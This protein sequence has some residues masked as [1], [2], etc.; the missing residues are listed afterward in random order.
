MPRVR[1][2]KE[3]LLLTCDSVKPARTNRHLARNLQA[4]TIELTMSV[5]HPAVTSALCR[6]SSPRK[7]QHEDGTCTPEEKLMRGDISDIS[8]VLHLTG[9]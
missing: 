9:A 1:V 4:L 6:T 7:S 2:C 8:D 3:S 5:V